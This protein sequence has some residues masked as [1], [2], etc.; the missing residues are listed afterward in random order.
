MRHAPTP[1]NEGIWVLPKNALLLLVAALDA[2]AAG[3]E[4]IKDPL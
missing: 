1:F 3:D 4:K 2:P